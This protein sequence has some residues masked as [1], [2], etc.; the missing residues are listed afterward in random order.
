M[1]KYLAILLLGF[2]SLVNSQ[3]VQTT[4]NLI[5]S[6]TTHTWTGIATG[7]LP[8][9]CGSNGSG[10]CAGGPGALYDTAT[11]SINFSYGQA[12][13]A[14]TIAI[15]NALASVGSGIK[16]VGYNWSWEINNLNRDNRQ[17]STD[18]LNAYIITTNSS[19]QA[20]DTMNRT[21]N[22][23]FDWTTFSGTR[24]YDQQYSPSDLGNLTVKFTGNDTGYW[25]GYFGPQV[26]NVNVGLNYGVDPCATNPAYSPNCPNYNTVST[27]SLWSGVTGPQSVAINQ[28]LS[29]TGVM[30]HGF[31]Y[32]YNYSVGGRFCNWMDFLGGC[33]GT[34]VYPSAS[35]TTTLT[36]NTGTVGYTETNTH[37]AGAVGTF[38][39]QLRLNASVPISTM[40]TFSMTPSTN[41]GAV[42]NNINAS[43]VYTADPCV[44]NPLSSTSCS[45]YQQ[46]FLGQQCA[47]NPLYSTQCAGY[48]TAYQTQQCTSNQLYNTQCP[49]YA[50]AYLSYQCSSNPLYSTTCSGYETAYRDQQCSI[51]PLYSTACSGYATAYHDQRCSLDPLYATDCVGY[52]A[53]YLT[54]QCSINPLYST[55][56]TGYAAAYKTQQCSISALYATDCPGYA[57]AYKLQQCTANPLYVTDCV[58]YEAAYH[59][60]QCTVNPLYMTDCSGY[61]A[62]YFTQQCNLNGLYDRACPNYSTAYAKKMVLEQQGTASIVATAGVI[63]STAPVSATTSTVDSSGTVSATPSTTGSVVVDKALPP[64]ATSA[65]SATAPAAPVQLVQQPKPEGAPQQQA[66]Q[67][68]KPEGGQPPPQMAQG[69][70]GGDK[71]AAPTA[72]QQLAER[73]AEAAKKDAVEKGKNLANEMGKAADM[74]AQ[75]QIQN[76]VIQAMG[77]TPG[78]D[79]YGK[80]VVPDGVGYKPFTV[81]NNQRTIDNR[82][83][84]RMFGG[85]EARHN[86]MVDSQYNLGK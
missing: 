23:K 22:T 82:A 18:T 6:G 52:G 2:S 72:R 14:Q 17:G 1:R 63:A 55:Q 85:S 28:A 40:G 77:F 80:S 12:T 41:N 13:V 48:A 39:K 53:A 4:P 78:F 45:G 71:P 61:Q 51:N 86:E 66:Q 5:T 37:A 31:D 24:T 47:S 34:W 3:T 68:K 60:Q 15:N 57:A 76:V 38:S 36:N 27:Q 7:A 29:G 64:P 25:G 26:R 43:V 79:S 16:V 83:N 54:Q 8:T 81:Y 58:G 11:S 56:C 32:S 9:G 44:S 69:G 84:Q 73:R 21:Y 74:E 65:N 33:L 19:G 42:I 67:E 35:M 75:K 62:A 10:G 20:I 30:V 49:G 59:N 46:A 50:A 70:Q